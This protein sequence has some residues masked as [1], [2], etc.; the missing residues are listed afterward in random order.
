MIGIQS[1]AKELRVPERPIHKIIRISAYDDPGEGWKDWNIG[2]ETTTRVS[3]KTMV[4]VFKSGYVRQL[5][6]IPFFTIGRKFSSEIQR[7]TCQAEFGTERLP[8]ESRPNSMD[9]TLYPDPVS[10][11]LGIKALSDNRNCTFS[12]SRRWRCP[13]NTRPSRRRR[14]FRRA[15]GRQLMDEAQLISWAMS[16]LI[17][18]NPSRLA[19]FATAMTKRFLALI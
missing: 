7:R 16:F 2:F 6:I 17:A 4:G 5:P 13:P 10:I 3:T 19:P 12:Q 18:S 1:N 14:G 11:M 8:I 15:A 9:R